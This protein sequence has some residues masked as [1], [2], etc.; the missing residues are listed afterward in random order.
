MATNIY[1]GMGA[2][3]TLYFW[4]DGMGQV[5]EQ[6][7][8]KHEALISN[9]STAQNKTLYFQGP[10][11]NDNNVHVLLLRL[12]QIPS[13]LQKKSLSISAEEKCRDSRPLVY[14][15]LVILEIESHELFA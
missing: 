1:P 4:V 14:F 8:S 15:A 2:I 3:K 9:P 13:W 6:L 11:L 12:A 10:T 5:V 7:P